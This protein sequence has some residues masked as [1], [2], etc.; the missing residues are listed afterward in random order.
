[1]GATATSVAARCLVRLVRLPACVAA[2]DTT[3]VHRCE[4]VTVALA[5]GTCAAEVLVYVVS[6]ALL[7]MAVPS[8]TLAVVAVNL[9]VI[10]VMSRGV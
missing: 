10:F 1:M 4:V 6:T 3:L 2:S 9:V 5:I 7:A 8:T